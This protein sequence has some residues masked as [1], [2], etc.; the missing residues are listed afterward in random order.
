MDKLVAESEAQRHFALVL[1]EAFALVGLLLAAIGIYGVLSGSVTE[2]TREIGVRAAMGATRGDILVLVL[3]QGMKLA[4]IG[5]VIGLAGALASSRA[6]THAVVRRFRARSRHVCGRHRRTAGRRG[7]RL[8]DSRA[9]G[10]ASRSGDHL[11]GGIKMKTL[12]AWLL[13]SR[14][15]FSKAQREREFASRDRKP[16]ANADRRQPSLR[17]DSGRSPPR[18]AVEAWRCGAD[19]ASLS[20]ARHHAIPRERRAGP[21]LHLPAVGKESGFRGD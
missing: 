14:G 5:I 21:A 18:G 15:L 1:F 13:R 19:Q 9:P 3:R 2:R 12:R 17:H 7:S 6:L 4:G 20:R 10:R 11:E 16:S 8:L